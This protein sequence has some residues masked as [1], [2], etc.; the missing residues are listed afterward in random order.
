MALTSRNPNSVP[1]GAASAGARVEIWTIPL[2]VPP[3]SISVATSLLSPDERTRAD[4][5]RN[6]QAQRNYIISHAALRQILANHLK[7]NPTEIPFC[8]GS[9]G[10]PALAGTAAG[11]FEFNLTHSGSLALVAVTSGAEVGI[12]VETIRPMPDALR[13]AERFFSAAESEALRELPATDHAA[14]FLNLWTRKESLAKATGFG[15]ANSLARFEVAWGTEA[16]VKAIDGDA[17]L[18]AQWTLHSFTPAPGYL[19]AVALRSPGA[20]FAFH[21]FT[22]AT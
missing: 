7:L 16:A 12:D 9:Y 1:S 17:R 13:I 18:A 15:I 8:T 20:Q 22:V 4:A 14:T 19:A 10:K 3:Q 21:E 6:E 11:R 2:D 5:F